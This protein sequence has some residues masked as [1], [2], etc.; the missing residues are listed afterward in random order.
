MIGSGGATGG[1]CD[2]AQPHINPPAANT[3]AMRMIIPRQ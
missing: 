1:G 2:K 3:A